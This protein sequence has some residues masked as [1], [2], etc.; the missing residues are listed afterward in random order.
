M[1]YLLLVTA[2]DPRFLHVINRERR[3]IYE[4]LWNHTWADSKNDNFS[5]NFVTVSTSEMR[6][7]RE[8]AKSFF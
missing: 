1:L 4:G 2:K 3:K 5:R 7:Y 6:S 8:I